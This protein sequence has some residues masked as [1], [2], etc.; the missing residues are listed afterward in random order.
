[1]TDRNPTDGPIHGWF[2][3]S[4]TNYQVLHRTLMQSMPT[5]WQERMVACLEELA[6][7]YEHI[8]QPEVFDVQAGTEHIVNEMT[9]D[10][11]AQAGIEWDWYAGETPPEGLTDDEF[12]EWRAQ[13][14]TETPVY[15]RG[16]GEVDPHQRVLIPRPDPIPHYRH[17]YIEP[18]FAGEQPAAE[19]AQ[20]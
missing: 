1:M 17:A 11:L 2:G 10:E 3:L 20:R 9:G 18:R 14:E 6:A 13:H 19:G 8:E 5:A 12:A 4:Y 7:A 16:G 15:Y